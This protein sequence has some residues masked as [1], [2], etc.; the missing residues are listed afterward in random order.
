MRLCLFIAVVVFQ[1]EFITTNTSQ[2][3]ADSWSII[4]F[5]IACMMEFL[6][7]INDTTLI[8]FLRKEE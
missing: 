3:M 4:F 5:V 8:K 1:E 6:S 2:D 7:I